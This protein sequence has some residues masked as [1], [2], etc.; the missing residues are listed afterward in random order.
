MVA[1]HAISLAVSMQIH[2][3]LNIEE[4]GHI[5]LVFQWKPWRMPSCFRKPYHTAK[6]LSSW[7]MLF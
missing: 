1:A 3:I 7:G 4:R 5:P 6:V 2:R